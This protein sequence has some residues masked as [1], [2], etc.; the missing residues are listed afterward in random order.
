MGERTEECGTARKKELDAS[1]FCCSKHVCSNQ[2]RLCLASGLASTAGLKLKRSVSR[3]IRPVGE[4][5]SGWQSHYI[6]RNGR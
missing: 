4:D 6:I 1:G 5:G 2:A 3:S